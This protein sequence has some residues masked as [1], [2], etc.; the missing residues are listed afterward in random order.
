MPDTLD[1]SLLRD[2]PA[3]DLDRL[4]QLRR[5]LPLTEP[6]SVATLAS[7][8]G[9]SQLLATARLGRLDRL[10]LADVRQV[11]FTSFLVLPKG[12]R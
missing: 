1:R 8:W 6:V 9:C 3:A 5:S 2:P 7:L 10:G 11:G 12:V 4:V